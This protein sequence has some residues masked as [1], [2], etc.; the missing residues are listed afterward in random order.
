MP[1]RSTWSSSSRR[2]TAGVCTRRR[3]NLTVTR[4]ATCWGTALARGWGLLGGPEASRLRR[5][6]LRSRHPLPR[7]YSCQGLVAALLVH[8]L[9]R[10]S[11][12]RGCPPAS[13]TSDVG[14]RLRRIRGDVKRARKTDLDRTPGVCNVGT[15]AVL[16]PEAFVCSGRERVDHEDRAWVRSE[17]NGERAFRQRASLGGAPLSN[18]L[19]P[20]SGA[21]NRTTGHCRS[22]QRGPEWAPAH[23]DRHGASPGRRAW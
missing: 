22:T 11:T 7:P 18:Q 13:G 14:A 19:L 21:D 9:T 20:S 2:A 8:P 5:H 17:V 4:W 1:L 12:G 3:N 6:P 16:V 10:A 23:P 15:A